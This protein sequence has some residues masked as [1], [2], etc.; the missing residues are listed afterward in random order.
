MKIREKQLIHE[1][2]LT[3]RYWD[4]EMMDGIIAV[5][6][7]RN[8]WFGLWNTYSYSLV[9]P[10]VKGEQN[11]HYMSR[12][13]M[14]NHKR[15]LTLALKNNI[16]KIK[17]GLW[18]VVDGDGHIPNLRSEAAMVEPEKPAEPTQTPEV[19]ENQN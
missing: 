13:M 7:Y 8:T 19:S 10:K 6:L 17:N 2:T 14:K 3:V 15:T 11:G 9:V 18:K 12:H 4:Y 5:A 16:L 1:Q